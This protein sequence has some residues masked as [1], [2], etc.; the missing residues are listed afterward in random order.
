M[1]KCRD[2][3][4]DAN[5]GVPTGVICGHIL[6][7]TVLYTTVCKECDT[8]YSDGGLAFINTY[9]NTHDDPLL[10]SVQS[11]LCHSSVCK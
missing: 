7:N 11:K 4:R 6:V 1:I 10:C 9:I 3:L 5:V 2:P 8:V